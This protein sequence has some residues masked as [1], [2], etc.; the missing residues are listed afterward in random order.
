LNVL[1]ISTSTPLHQLWLHTRTFDA[2]AEQL[3]GRGEPRALT[4]LLW[5]LLAQAGVQLHDL[6]VLVCDVGPGSFTGLRQG[7]ATVR[8][9]GWAQRKPVMA[10]GSLQ[11]MVAE[12]RAH[13]ATGAVAVA[14]PARTGVAYVG[15]SPEPEVLEQ[16]LVS[17]D[18][19]EA[20][21]AERAAGQAVATVLPG[22][23]LLSLARQARVVVAEVPEHPV[24]RR[25][26]T[27]AKA[28]PHLWIPALHLAPAYLAATE[29]EVHRGCTVE[30]E[31]LPAERRLSQ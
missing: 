8:T 15:W 14:L 18:R 26:A 10:V 28:A 6:D 7:L 31:V 29:A 2:G 11:A 25:L 5:A 17:L 24:A 27:M 1:A 21:W 3:A 16:T 4:A 19:A 23:W 20:F 9:L 13:G 30:A 12:V 22:P